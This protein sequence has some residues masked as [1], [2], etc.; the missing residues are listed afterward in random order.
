M[1]E[2]ERIG[3]GGG[4]KAERRREEGKGGGEGGKQ[5]ML[6]RDNSR[7]RREVNGRCQRKRGL[8]GEDNMMGQEG[9]REGGYKI[10]GKGGRMVVKSVEDG[11]EER[12]GV[13]KDT[14]PSD[15][16]NGLNDGETSGLQ[17]YTATVASITH[18]SDASPVR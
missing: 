6:G 7:G 10:E 4:R 9:E 1:K 15:V 17:Y 18:L 2:E 16:T 3:R 5:M 8:Q 13:W 14:T 12:D 11:K